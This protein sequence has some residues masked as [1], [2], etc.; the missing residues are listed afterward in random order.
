MTKTQLPPFNP[1]TA[2]LLAVFWDRTS[3]RAMTNFSPKARLKLA[4]AGDEP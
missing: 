1:I 3:H 2:E 4:G